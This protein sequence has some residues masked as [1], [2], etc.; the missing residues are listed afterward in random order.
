[1]SGLSLNFLPNKTIASLSAERYLSQFAP[2]EM[3]SI[4]DPFL[5]EILSIAGRTFPTEM[6]S[7]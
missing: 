4:E 6:L 1:M 7:V 2:A 3:L 5:T